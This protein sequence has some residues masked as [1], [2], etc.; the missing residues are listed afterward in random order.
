[1]KDALITL[2]LNDK[3]V[4]VFEYL[5]EY[6]IS[7]ASEIAKAIHIPK[8]T[9]NFLADT[10]W[11]QGYLKKS[12]R[13]KTG[14]FEVDT[15]HFKESVN[16]HLTKQQ[17]ALEIVI[18]ELENK[19]KFTSDK[20]KITF[21]E[22]VESCQQAYLELLKQDVFYELGA[23]ADLENAF[24]KKFMDDFIAQR[25]KSGVFC[26]SIWTTGE[27]ENALQ[28]LDSIQN[29]DLKIFERDKYGRISSS[30]AIYNDKVLILNLSRLPIGVLIQNPQFAQTMKTIYMICKRK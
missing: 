21:L 5:V 6:G 17:E 18:P 15:A 26:D 8:S 1:M 22:W 3:Q 24:G 9:V 27:I 4:Q 11:Q 14:F 19:L 29:R 23:H 28:Q 12:F 20:P 2:G 16:T 7:P 25:V 13:G 30:I 10:L